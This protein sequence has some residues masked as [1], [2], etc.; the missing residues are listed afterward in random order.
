MKILLNYSGMSGSQRK[1]FSQG[2][3]FGLGFPLPLGLEDCFYL[4][5]A[6]ILLIS[7]WMNLLPFLDE[8]SW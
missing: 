8:G 4:V 3:A 6:V 5:K 1:S 7:G 2:Q